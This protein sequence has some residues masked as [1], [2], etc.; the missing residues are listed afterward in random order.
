MQ[1]RGAERD[2]SAVH[3]LDV[4]IA[5]HAGVDRD[6]TKASIGAAEVLHAASRGEKIT[7]I[8]I[9]NAIYGMTGGQMAPTSLAGQVTT[10]SPLGRD[11]AVTGQPFH[12]AEVF[13]GHSGQY[14][15]VEDTIKGFSEILEG[16][17][18][19][20]NEDEFYMKGSIDQV[21]K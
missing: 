5:H 20:K 11:T 12:V 19:D 8:F 2:A 4:V 7:I 6:L 15:K 3:A 18:D 16:K 9:N 1:K 17:H 13:T 21:G 10:S 14:V